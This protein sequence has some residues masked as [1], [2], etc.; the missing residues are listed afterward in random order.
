M[1]KTK[2]F[3]DKVDEIW[4]L[5]RDEAIKAQ[6]SA[7]V[8]RDLCALA[9]ISTEAGLAPQRSLPRLRGRAREGVAAMR[10]TRTTPLPD[11]PLPRRG[12]APVYALLCAAVG[13]QR[14]HWQLP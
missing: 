5:V 10:R 6:E 7:G 2:A 12:S 11:P 14:R 3:V 13:T 9:R 1:F 8:M 4:N